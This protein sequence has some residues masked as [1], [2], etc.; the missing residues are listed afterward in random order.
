MMGETPNE[1]S[2]FRRRGGAARGIADPRRESAAIEGQ[3]LLVETG[4]PAA[5]A[6]VKLL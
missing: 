4:E 6:T 2:A 1:T 3:V 5:G